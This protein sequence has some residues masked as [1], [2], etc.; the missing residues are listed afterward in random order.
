MRDKDTAPETPQ[1][2]EDRSGVSRLRLLDFDDLFLLS[3]LLEGATIAAT[4]RQLGL[5]QPA[6]TQRVRKIE[7]VFAEAVLQKAGR[8]VRLTK[9]GH[10]ICVKAA[11]ALALMR[12]VAEQSKAETL[13]VGAGPILHAAWLWPALTEL[14]ETS[15]ASRFNAQVGLEDEVLAALDSGVL[16]AAITTQTPGGPASVIELGEEEFVMVASPALAGNLATAADLE[17]QVLLEMDRSFGLLARIERAARAQLRFKDAWFV[18]GVAEVV[19]AAQAGHGVA[20]LP[21]QLVANAVQAGRLAVVLPELDIPPV[22]VRLAYRK[23]R[24]SET[25]IELLVKALRRRP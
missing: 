24:I 3:H 15:P 5:T 13:T 10:A 6:I 4:A 7:R 9:A 25:M 16:A 12:E 20:V 2:H 19:A 22:P 21:E 8:H 11:D 14:R 17:G 18:G 23:D 1:G